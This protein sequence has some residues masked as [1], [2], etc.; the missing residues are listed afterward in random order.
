MILCTAIPEILLIP[1]R[2][3]KLTTCVSIN[4]LSVPLF[5]PFLCIE[6]FVLVAAGPRCVKGLA[7]TFAPLASL[8]SFAV[9]QLGR[10][11]FVS[12]RSPL[13]P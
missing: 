12:D 11:R 5:T 2:N 9:K 7:V 10:S 3:S 1:R 4:V 8:A 13:L 6:G